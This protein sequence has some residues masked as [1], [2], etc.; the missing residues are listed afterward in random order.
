M[1]LANPDKKEQEIRKGT[2]LDKRQVI[3]KIDP[4]HNVHR[5]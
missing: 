2:R 3:Y 5:E 1:M 4:K